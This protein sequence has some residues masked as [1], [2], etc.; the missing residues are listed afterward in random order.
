[1]ISWVTLGENLVV[2]YTKQVIHIWATLRY[3]NQENLVARN[4]P[5]E[6]S[7]QREMLFNS[8]NPHAIM[9]CV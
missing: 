8:L 1:M 6:I 2:T 9:W 7:E 4:A 5:R 3:L